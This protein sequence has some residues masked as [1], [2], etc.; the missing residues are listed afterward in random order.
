MV[1]AVQMDDARPA[2]PVPSRT[3][4]AYDALLELILGL[5]LAPGAPLAESEIMQRLGVGRTPL[6]EAVGRLATE[7]LVRVFPRRGTFVT[8]VNLADLP[9][10]TELRIGL[11]RAAAQAAASRSLPSDHTRLRR[12]G[13]ASASPGGDALSNDVL[14]HRAVYAAARNPYLEESAQRYLNLSVRMWRYIAGVGPAGRQDLFD[15]SDLI[16]AIVARDGRA[17][18]ALAE[19]HVRRFGA[20]VSEQLQTGTNL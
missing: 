4:E 19:E 7:H 3:S 5:E 12:L 18:A 14:L 13:A 2:D 6:R 10:I 9:L 8:D 20:A 16:D 11:E 1:S 17:A 15:H